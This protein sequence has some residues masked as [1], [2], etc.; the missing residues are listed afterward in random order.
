MSPHLGVYAPFE[1]YVSGT[2]NNLT[3]CGSLNVVNYN[4]QDLSAGATR[5]LLVGSLKLQSFP[6]QRSRVQYQV[7][8]AAVSSNPTCVS[9]R[10]PPST[11]VSGRTVTH[12]TKLQCRNREARG[13][14]WP[15][16]VR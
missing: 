10:R 7:S 15:L 14:V 5:E 9:T 11:M 8:T 6:D 12:V 3:V 1:R 2:R 16:A 4:Q 13:Q